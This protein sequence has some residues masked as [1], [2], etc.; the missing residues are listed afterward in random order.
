MMVELYMLLDRHDLEDRLANSGCCLRCVERC[1]PFLDFACGEYQGEGNET[2]AISPNKINGVAHDSN[3]KLNGHS[4]HPSCFVCLDLLSERRL[5]DLIR[6]IKDQIKLANYESPHF[7]LS[8]VTVQILEIRQVLLALWLK[9]RFP[10]LS[11]ME[12]MDRCLPIKQLLKDDLCSHLP[13]ALGLEY[14]TN[15]AFEVKVETEAADTGFFN[16]LEKL[17]PDTFVMKTKRQ[18]R[19]KK[20]PCQIFSRK[21]VLAFFSKNSTETLE[22][23]FPFPSDPRSHNDVDKS[24]AQT[25]DDIFNYRV[26]LEHEPIFVG[27]RYNKYS[28]DLPQTP[29]IVEGE[30]LKESSIEELIVGPIDAQLRADEFK[31]SSSGRE[32][33]DVRCLGDGRPFIVE[34]LN[35]RRVTLT[36]EELRRVEDDINQGGG[37]KIR[38]TKMAM[39][40]DREKAYLRKMENDKSKHYVAICHSLEKLTDHDMT[41]LKEVRDNLVHQK[42]PL[43]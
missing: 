34:C 32:D 31:F 8:L 27:G 7:V 40:S 1:A 42:T 21:S 12:F 17:D 38:V 39:V 16:T 35:P 10:S 30:R 24:N 15:S 14:R 2:K 11:L 22:G 23:Q 4:T 5:H 29:W 43:R 28:R 18:Q 9:E 20:L 6:Y 19:A 37:D 26:T 33:I 25:D 3:S 13:N 36:E 41:K